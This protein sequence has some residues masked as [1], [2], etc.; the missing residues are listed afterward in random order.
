MPDAP[1]S[2]STPTAPLSSAT[3]ADGRTGSSSALTRAAEKWFTGRGI[4]A[5]ALTVG[6]VRSEELPAGGEAI[7]FPYVRRGVTVNRKHRTGK[8]ENRRFWMD[9][10][11]ELVLWN[12]D[13]LASNPDHVYLVEGE[14][15][16]LSFMEA[17]LGNV[18]SVPN[19]APSSVK[20]EVVDPEQDEQFRYLWNC[21]EELAGKRYVIAVDNDEPGLRLREALVAR[22]QP[23]NCDVIEWP[24]GVKDAN[25]YLREVG[26]QAFREY[27]LASRKPYPVRGLSGWDDVLPTPPVEVFPVGIPG[28]ED[29]VKLSRGTMSVVTG[30]P[31]MGKSAF[32]KHL[33]CEMIRRHGW[34]V[35]LASFEDEVYRHLMPELVQIMSGCRPGQDARTALA[36]DDASRLLRRH[37]SFIADEG[38]VDDEQDLEWLVGLARAA[39]KRYGTDLL[40]VD[41]WNEIEHSWGRDKTE[42]QYLNHSLRNLRRLARE[43][44]LHLMIVAHPTKIP[45][46]VDAPNLYNISGGAAWANKVDIGITIHQP[47]FSAGP[48]G[49]TEAHVLKVKRPEFGRR[50]MVPL[51]FNPMNRRFEAPGSPAVRDMEDSFWNAGDQ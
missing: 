22:L 11:G 18:L 51:Q 49:P 35:T 21:R 37:I 17:G 6:G 34:N 48:G 30:I 43:L 25:D 8:G 14:V 32:V 23:E 12:L 31:N 42:A 28:M 24:E 40:I 33:A 16:A 29:R 5:G 36:R 39:K 2:G 46:S 10:G 44:R 13:C 27:V 38:Q 45:D 50:G 15:D 7:V 19:G 9:K 41:P 26:T 1:Q 20:D 3:T 47:N 4:H